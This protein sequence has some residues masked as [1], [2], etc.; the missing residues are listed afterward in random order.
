MEQTGDEN[1]SLVGAGGAEMGAGGQQLPDVT[2]GGSGSGS[3]FRRIPGLGKLPPGSVRRNR[4][5]PSGWRNL[6]GLRDS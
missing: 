2:I 6:W 4:E 5:G 3:I 1:D